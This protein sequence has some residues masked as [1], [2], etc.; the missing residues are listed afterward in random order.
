M[1]VENENTAVLLDYSLAST[2]RSCTVE[3]HV[4]VAFWRVL[5]EASPSCCECKTVGAG[6]S[7]V[8]GLLCARGDAE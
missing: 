6:V 3:I 8:C 2:S 1:E 4:A 7:G 5:L